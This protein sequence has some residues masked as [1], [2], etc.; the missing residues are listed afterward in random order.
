[1]SDSRLKVW[2]KTK[3]TATKESELPLYEPDS[4]EKLKMVIERTSKADYIIFPKDPCRA[5]VIH[6]QECALNPS[7]P[8]S[9]FASY[10]LT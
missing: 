2:F 4:P 3:T 9:I 5:Q 8:W 6:M 10:Q 1:M 7:G